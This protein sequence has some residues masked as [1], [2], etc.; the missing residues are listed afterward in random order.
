MSSDDE[1]LLMGLDTMN[2]VLDKNTQ[3]VKWV[4]KPA[5]EPLRKGYATATPVTYTR[6]EYFDGDW[7][8]RYVVKQEERQYIGCKQAHNCMCE[9]CRSSGP[10]A[11]APCGCRI[12]QPLP[13]VVTLKKPS[14]LQRLLDYFFW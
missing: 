1:E 10:E 6:E 9:T 2:L 11:V 13:K 5:S 3:T 4:E 8:T 12:H 14:W 7:K